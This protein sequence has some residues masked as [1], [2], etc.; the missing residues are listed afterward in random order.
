MPLYIVRHASAGDR[1][2]GPDDRLRPLDAIG[3]ARAEQIATQFSDPSEGR[4][5]SSP[6]TRCMQTLEPLAR[7][8]GRIV[9]ATPAL[10][11]AQPFE[12]VLDLLASLPDGSVLCSHGDLIPDVI[13]A[14]VRRGMDI[15]GA[16]SW[17]KGALWQLER[18][19]GTIRSA[20]I[21][22]TANVSKVRQ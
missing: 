3:W 17:K 10:G 9:E 8:T 15:Q 2:F 11:E 6:F 4:L 22:T 13:D 20:A 19:D 5:L 14:L 21:V 7:R 16:P 1:G 18:V 12:P